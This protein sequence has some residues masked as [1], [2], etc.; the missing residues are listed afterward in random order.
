MWSDTFDGYVKKTLEVLRSELKA[1]KI[2]A[3]VLKW[4]TALTTSQNIYGFSGFKTWTNEALDGHIEMSGQVDPGKNVTFF[5]DKFRIGHALVP[6]DDRNLDVL[7]ACSLDPLIPWEIE[8]ID[9]KYQDEIA[10]RASLL[11]KPKPL[12]STTAPAKPKPVRQKNDKGRFVKTQT[13]I[14]ELAAAGG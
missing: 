6:V 13:T 7:A 14:E 4:K 1:A 2:D 9:Q 10:K 12:S 5:P 11:Q 8:D 3:V